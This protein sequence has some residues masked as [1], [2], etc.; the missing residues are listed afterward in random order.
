MKKRS[1]LMNSL[2][3]T[4]IAAVFFLLSACITTTGE[5]NGNAFY[6][7]NNFTVSLMNGDWTVLR[8]QKGVVNYQYYE[9]TAY[10][11]SFS[12]KK[13]NGLIGVHSFVM[14]EVGQ[15]RSLE[16]H[17]DSIASEF[18]GMKLS[19]RMIKVDGID[20]VELLLSGNKMAKLILLKKGK[21]GFLLAYTNTPAYFDQSLSE[22]DKFIA[23]FKTL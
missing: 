8:Q 9:N 2:K 7:D 14:S 13:S 3:I 6:L 18:G 22:F 21:M 23:T 12:H 15:A 10:Q 19:Q 11:I 1:F 16:V 4:T 5:I 20:A 17:A